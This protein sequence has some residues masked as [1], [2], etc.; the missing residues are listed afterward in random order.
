MSMPNAWLMRSSNGRNLDILVVVI[1][2]IFSLN[3]RLI[4]RLIELCHLSLI[5]C[6]RLCLSLDY[7]LILDDLIILSNWVD[8]VSK[9]E[10]DHKQHCNNYGHDQFGL[11]VL[12]PV[13]IEFPHPDGVSVGTYFWQIF[14]IFAI[15]LFLHTK[16][17]LMIF[18]HFLHKI[19]QLYQIKL[20][21]KIKRIKR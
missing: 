3:W 19:Y 18:S 8:F 5:R 10:D 12:F 7:F 17:S 21:K 15:F 2:A 16:I 1:I 4:V 20:L 14:H 13:L 9:E 11:F 6:W